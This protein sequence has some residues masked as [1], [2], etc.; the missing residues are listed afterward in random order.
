MRM[1]KKWVLS[2]VLL[3]GGLSLMPVQALAQSPFALANIG[4]PIDNADARMTGR[5]GWG[6]AVHDSLNPGFMN[7]ASLTALRHVA[8][9]FTSYGEKI[10]SSDEYGSRQVHR[11]LLPDI[12]VGIPIIKGRLAFST[13]I[14]VGRSFE[15]RT[16]QP[17]TWYAEE[18]TITGNKQFRREGTLWQIPTGLSLRLFGNLSVAGTVGM[19]NGTIRETTDN[20]FLQPSGFTGNPLYLANRKVREDEFTGT[21]TTLSIH[22]GS[23]NGLALGASWTPGHNL[24]VD[25][26]ISMGGLSARENSTWTFDIPETFKAGFQLK[27]TGRWRVGGDGIFQRYS[28]FGGNLQWAS[29]TVDEYSASLGLERS[30]AFERHGGMSNLPLRFGVKYR[31]WGF[32]VGGQEVEE[33][34]ISMGTGFPFNRKMGMLDTSLSYSVIGDESKNGMESNVWRLTV[35]V[36][37][38]EKWW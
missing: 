34:V 21:Q 7:V 18:D 19:V 23:S 27:L 36:T 9:K 37:G 6:M 20:F 35:S 12:R 30:V 24:D 15:Y 38:L 28:E 11:S 33:K 32:L 13:G 17:M 3:A 29:D 16:L 2:L 4:Q 10:D 22:F 25:R 1:F 31:R 8:V 26:K 5:G 14:E